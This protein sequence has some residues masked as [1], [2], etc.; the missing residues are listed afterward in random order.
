[1]PPI[2]V[3]EKD[4]DGASIITL[5]L[6][7]SY[8]ESTLVL[9][10][11]RRPRRWVPLGAA[12][13]AAVG[14]ACLASALTA[15]FAGTRAP[16]PR[17]VEKKVLV[18]VAATVAAAPEPPAAAPAIAATPAKTERTTPTASAESEKR[19]ASERPSTKSEGSGATGKSWRR[20]DPGALGQAPVSA[21]RL[22]AGFPT[23]PGF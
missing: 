23:N 18:P 11:R 9:A 2:I 13:A 19:T 22:R 6:D 7:E 12:V 21:Q 17:I 3:Q 1:L 10:G 8:H 16:A 20:D 14:S 5:P 4:D 15:L